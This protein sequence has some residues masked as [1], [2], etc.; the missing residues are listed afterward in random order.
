MPN[1]TTHAEIRTTTSLS[2]ADAETQLRDALKAEGFGVLTEVDVQA[3][4]REKLG[5]ETEPYRILG[6]CNP[7]FA[8]RALQ[9]WKGFGLIAPCNIAIYEA[10]GHRVVM[11]YNPADH[12]EVRQNADLYALA[13]DASAAIRRAVESLPA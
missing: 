8:Q 10:A 5:A 6:A 13:K 11:A 1:P 3:V 12:P 7:T 9:M 2:M 4:L